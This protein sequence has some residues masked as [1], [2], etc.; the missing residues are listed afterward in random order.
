MN[1]RDAG[2][3]HELRVVVPRAQDVRAMERTRRPRSDRALQERHRMRATIACLA[4]LVL[5]SCGGS[6]P[7]PPLQVGSPSSE[8]AAPACAYVTSWGEDDVCAVSVPDGRRLGCARTGSKPH[9]IALSRDGSRLYV[10][11]EG[12]DT[13]TVVDPAAMQAVGEVP[14]GRVPN[15]IALTPAGDQ[16]WVTNNHD[17]SVSVVDTATLTVARTIPVG[18]RPHII[19]TDAARNAAIITS[20]GDGALEVYDLSSYERTAQIPVFAYPRVLAVAGSGDV[21]FLTIRW[22]NGALAID[23]G[24]KGPVDRIA[25][26]EPRFAPEGKDAHGIALTPDK[27]VL[28]LTTQMTDRLTFIDAGTMEVLGDVE[29]GR[30]PN[31]VEVTPD[32]RAAVVSTTDDD[33]VSIVD[34]ATR[35]VITTVAVGKN[36]KR[37]A[38]G[39]CPG[40]EARLP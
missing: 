19:V 14:V 27:R 8:P 6:T 1:D 12:A 26:G 10:S 36:P 7:A 16:V 33:S 21:A 30:N 11:N 35:R 5:G 34:V 18:R 25:L 3:A 15:Q 4:A 20:E 17:D 40:A 2:S 29:V 13:L 28:L 32:G 23:L 37:L 39:Q 22:L 24:G 38:V 31:W 9:G